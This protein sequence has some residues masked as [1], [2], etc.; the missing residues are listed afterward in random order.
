MQREI[1]ISVISS[2]VGAL[3]AFAASVFMG[4][5]VKTVSDTQ[6]RELAASVVNVQSQ[7]EVLIE[8]MD[9]SGLFKGKGER[10]EQGKQGE[11]GPVGPPGQSVLVRNQPYADK[12]I[13]PN[14]NETWTA[15]SCS[16]GEVVTG[17]G[18][19][20]RADAA[21]C[22]GVTVLRSLASSEQTWSI[23]AHNK[24]SRALTVRAQAICTKLEARR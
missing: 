13:G 4:A 20:C 12:I 5:F 7:R 21:L 11:R 14:G 2:V 3:L 15:P 22:E 16:E 6:I 8:A 10:G 1:A 23:Q 18:W 9:R 24:N 17:G 19:E